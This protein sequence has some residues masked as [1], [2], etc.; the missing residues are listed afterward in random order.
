MDYL[1]NA[2][3]LS[4]IEDIHTKI[5]RQTRFM[6]RRP[7]VAIIKANRY[8]YDIMSARLKELFDYCDVNYIECSISTIMGA[9]EKELIINE[10][11]KNCCIDGILNFNDYGFT[12]NCFANKNL[13]EDEGQILVDAIYGAL[14]EK[15]IDIKYKNCLI[16]SNSEKLNTKLYNRLERDSNNIFIARNFKSETIDKLLEI[17][18]VVF[19][20]TCAT[21]VHSVADLVGLNK[22]KLVVDLDITFY[23]NCMAGRFSG[24]GKEEEARKYNNL[25]TVDSIMDNLYIQ[26]IRNLM[27]RI[28]GKGNE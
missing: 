6:E 10:L 27:S 3:L 1:Y 2:Y 9:K 15:N 16:L 13:W 25:V 21:N 28:E 11:N 22:D 26:V 5:K 7:C 18:N 20:H 12:G 8:C 17:S 14:A 19:L 23:T 4:C 24:H